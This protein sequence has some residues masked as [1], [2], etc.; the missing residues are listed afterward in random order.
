MF[1]RIESLYYGCNSVNRDSFGVIGEEIDASVINFD[2]D[3]A[4]IPTVPYK[5]LN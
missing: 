1:S 5:V 3:E 4:I 2:T